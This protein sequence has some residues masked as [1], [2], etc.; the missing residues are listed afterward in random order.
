MIMFT[1]HLAAITSKDQMF[2]KW[3]LR[4]FFFLVHV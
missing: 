2:G 4:E 1:A 3:F